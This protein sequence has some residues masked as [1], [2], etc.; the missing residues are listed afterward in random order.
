[1]SSP[2]I[3][4]CVY[5][6]SGPGANTGYLRVFSCAAHYPLIYLEPRYTDD[7]KGE[8]CSV[9]VCINSYMCTG[10]AAVYLHLYIYILRVCV[11]TV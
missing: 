2:C 7:I 1:M 5:L 11:R 3:H 9:Y 8:M 6:L 4:N 10:T